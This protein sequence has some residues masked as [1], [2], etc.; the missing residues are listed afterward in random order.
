LSTLLKGYSTLTPQEQGTVAPYLVPPIYSDAWVE[1]AGTGGVIVTQANQLGTRSASSVRAAVTAQAGM[2]SPDWGHLATQHFK[3]WYRTDSPAGLYSAN[4]AAQAALNIATW[5]EYAYESLSGLLGRGLISDAGQAHSGGDGLYDIYVVSLAGA[6]GVTEPFPQSGC[7]PQPTYILINVLPAVDPGYARSVVAHELM[8]AFQFT[9]DQIE[10]DDTWMSE[11]TASWAEYYVYKPF[12]DRTAYEQIY[13]MQY[14]GAAL[15]GKVTGAAAN[16]LQQEFRWPIDQSAGTRADCK[17][18]YCDYVFFVYLSNVAGDAVIPNIFSKWQSTDAIHA[19]DGA[20]GG[21]LNTVWHDYTHKMFNYWQ[22][23]AVEA[24]FF[25]TY[26]P[27]IFVYG[28][29]DTYSEL[30]GGTIDV[31]LNGAQ[32]AEYDAEIKRA[33]DPEIIYR[34]SATPLYFT[35]N[36]PSVSY[37]AFLNPLFDQK[38]DQDFKIYGRAKISGKWEGTWSDWTH[39]DVVTWCRDK[40]SERIE[41]LVVILSNGSI[42]GSGM[43]GQSVQSLEPDLAVSN[44]G[45]WDWSG[46]ASV[47]TTTTAGLTTTVSAT[48]VVLQR[49]DTA[50]AINNEFEQDSFT[51]LAQGTANLTASGSVSVACSVNEG[52]LQPPANVAAADATLDIHLLGLPIESFTGEVLGRGGITHLVNIPYSLVCGGMTL[53]TT[54]KSGLEEWMKFPGAPSYRAVSADGRSITG[55]FTEPPD[56]TGATTT[57][58]WDL[59]AVVEQ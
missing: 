35:F 15:E 10:C 31:S 56:G 50:N 45:C 23:P 16:P 26:D 3:I 47:T 11:A 12:P 22:T 33:L 4:D 57:E 40:K 20:L 46:T 7:G 48:G 52:P 32:S 25:T 2:V 17:N 29:F 51:S 13:A 36:D 53:D 30:P 8:H 39:K 49:D 27:P 55:S 1:S 14:F 5:V 58:H 37:V 24:D 18:G 38:V 41:E 19:I 54:P 6:N 44:I 9:Y 21:T 43:S 42:S 34:L 28:I 59:H